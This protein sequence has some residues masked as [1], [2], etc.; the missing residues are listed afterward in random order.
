LCPV[1]YKHGM[2][3]EQ[4][5]SD[6]LWVNAIRMKCAVLIIKTTLPTFKSGLENCFVSV[7]YAT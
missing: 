7:G 1:F 2:D 4:M 5:T 6:V 3:C